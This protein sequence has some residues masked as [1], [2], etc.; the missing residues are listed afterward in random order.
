[1]IKPKNDDFF[2]LKYNGA[3]MRIKKQI[4]DLTWSELMEE[5]PRITDEEGEI[6]TILSDT[7]IELIDE[8][9]KEKGDN[10]EKLCYFY[11][12]GKLRKKNSGKKVRIRDIYT[13]GTESEWYERSFPHLQENTTNYFVKRKGWDIDR[14]WGGLNSYALYLRTSWK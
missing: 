2:T 12:I 8:D 13:E 11:Q 3:I 5:V 7:V 1:M 10:L 9:A 14:T 6:L 4:G